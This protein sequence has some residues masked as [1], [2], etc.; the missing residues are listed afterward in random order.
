MV[1]LIT[2]H[3]IIF[4]QIVYGT[5]VIFRAGLSP[6][7]Q[8]FGEAKNLL[9]SDPELLGHGAVEDEIDR[10]VGQG[11]HVHHLPQG[12]VAGNKKFIP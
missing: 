9:E 1:R 4:Q 12:G 5:L 7:T 8:M 6:A 2:H 3:E 10:A 11:Q